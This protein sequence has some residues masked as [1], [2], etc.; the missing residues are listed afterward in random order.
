MP[1]GQTEQI[2]QW[3]IPMTW[4]HGSKCLFY[5]VHE[6]SLVR[7]ITFI[8]MMMRA[9]WAHSLTTC[10]SCSRCCSWPG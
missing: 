3:I 2:S 4:G 9:P 10:S 8:L 7:A 5:V 1:V 6:A